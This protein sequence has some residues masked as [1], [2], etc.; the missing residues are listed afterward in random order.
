MARIFKI[1]SEKVVA[2]ASWTVTDKI[3]SRRTMSF[4]VVDKLQLES[5]DNGDDVELLN[6]TTT[7][8][9][10]IIDN[11]DVSE[12]SAGRL[13]W[14]VA[15]LDNSALADRRRI[16]AVYEDTLAGDIARDLITQKLGQE[17][18]TPGT[19][20]DG[21]L[22]KKAVF[23]YITCAHAL[24]YLRE[25]TGFIWYIDED[26]QLNFYDR[27]TFRAPFDITPSVQHSDFRLTSKMDGYRNT[28]YT[29]GG[30]TETAQQDLERPTPKPDGESRTFITRFPLARQP[31][32]E[33]NI[34]GLGWV[35]IPTS[36]IGVNGLDQDKKWYW[37]YNSST[38]TQADT[39]DVLRD[40]EGGTR[41]A[42]QIRITYIGLR[43][44]FV[45]LD[46]PTEIERRKDAEPLSSG[47]YEELAVE[48]SINNTD[49]A[50]QYSQGLLETYGEVKD[51][52]S[53]NTE[54]EGLRAG[55]LIRVTKPLYGI[56]D[57]FLIESV[58]ARPVSANS[59]QYSVKALDG[60]AVGGWEEFFKK[61]VRNQKDFT[62][63]EDEV[64]IIIQSQIEAQGQQGQY[65][66]EVVEA[67]YPA[68]DLYPSE[69]LYP[70]TLTQEVTLND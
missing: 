55:Q 60:A 54:K 34:N 65:Q 15:S 27:A 40:D 2:D 45:V 56:D 22:I 35:E 19:I 41:T 5:L 26:R 6:G 30:K 69:T 38:I 12:P 16:A 7:I 67:L 66:I 63:A 18:V 42:D 61:L 1:N 8:Y 51:Y 33:L 14:S 46:N 10:G 25:I 59:I 3:N 21:A 36:D 53:F 62:I 68:E 23:N 29:R 64:V 43:N 9:A 31:V 17:N 57:D 47:I 4:G 50:I 24:D 48:Q 13:E 44:L 39:E 20:Q 49:Q 37:G 52:V 11:Y 32:I 70:G 28:Q 58:S